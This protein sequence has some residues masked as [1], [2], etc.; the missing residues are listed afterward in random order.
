[1]PEKRNDQKNND[2]TFPGMSNGR[3]LHRKEALA[4]SRNHYMCLIHVEKTFGII[5]ARSLASFDSAQR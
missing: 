5:L 2:T 1:M 3:T 4:R